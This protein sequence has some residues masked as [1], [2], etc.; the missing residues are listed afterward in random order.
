LKLKQ[1]HLLREIKFW[2]NV[3]YKY[4]DIYK[5]D[6]ADSNDLLKSQPLYKDKN[7]IFQLDKLIDISNQLKYSCRA[8]KEKELTYTEEKGFLLIKIYKIIEK[9]I[10]INSL[11]L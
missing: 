9:Y 11:F 6:L 3:N 2:E 5:M 1:L 8:I 10:K 4:Y 7:E